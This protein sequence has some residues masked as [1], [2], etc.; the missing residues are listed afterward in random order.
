MLSSFSPRGNKF[1]LTL[2]AFLLLVTATFGQVKGKVIRVADG[3]TFTM[4]VDGKPY[5]VR[6]HGVDCPEKT[7]DFYDVAR[8]FLSKLIMHQEVTVIK[9]N[10]DR[11]GRVV[12]IAFLEE[13]NIN[14]Q[15][16]KEGLA[17]HF[18]RYDKNQNW[19]KLEE[20]ARREGR[21]L[22]QSKNTVPPW[23]FRRRDRRKS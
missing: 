9:R 3:D 22:W 12:G 18:T 10:K 6:L 20:A 23:E 13:M 5:K 8:Q 17:W 1:F 2:V 11:Y 16:L 4:L 14:E 7:Q 21:G 19:A 15:L